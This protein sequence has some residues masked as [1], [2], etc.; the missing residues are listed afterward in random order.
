MIESTKSQ[1]KQ[2]IEQAEGLLKTKVM[3]ESDLDGEES[4]ADYFINRLS[5]NSL[6]LGQCNGDWSSVTKD[7]KGEGEAIAK[8][9]AIVILIL[10]KRESNDSLKAVT[11][12][13]HQLLNKLRE[14]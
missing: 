9:K 11:S 6:L 10:R 2:C 5:M 8:P 4:G 3:V 14:I 1:L 13:L 12:T 7:A